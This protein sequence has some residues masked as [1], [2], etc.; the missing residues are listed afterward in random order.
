MGKM[1]RKIGCYTKEKKNMQNSFFFF[2]FFFFFC[3]FF[4]L[5][6]SRPICGVISLPQCACSEVISVS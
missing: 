4:I 3:F 1:K 6:T 5:N 2:F